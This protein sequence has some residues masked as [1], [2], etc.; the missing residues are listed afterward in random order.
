MKISLFLFVFMVA[1]VSYGTNSTVTVT[2][3]FPTLNTDNTPI[4]DL[5]GAKVY[6]GFSSSNY[7]HV[8]DVP[9]GQPG[10]T[11]SFTVSN[12]IAGVIYYL[13]G[14]AYNVAGLESDFCDEVTKI[15]GLSGPVNLRIGNK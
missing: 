3:R 11:K 9:G 7:I 10:E 2:W 6:Y 13:N 1:S 4:T 15:A 14:T 5:A 8:V 12:L